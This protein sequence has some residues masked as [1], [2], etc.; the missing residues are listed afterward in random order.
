M[1]GRVVCRMDA[2]C[3]RRCRSREEG[4][5]RGFRDAVDKYGGTYGGCMS[6][7][8]DRNLLYAK[9]LFCSVWTMTPTVMIGQ[10][11]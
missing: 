9:D 5:W 11:W 7:G 1:N 3:H 8:V 4:F 6:R 10:S 2:R